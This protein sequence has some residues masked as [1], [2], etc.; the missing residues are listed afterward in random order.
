M[1]LNVEMVGSN[2]FRID[3]NKFKG[4]SGRILRDTSKKPLMVQPN[5]YRTLMAKIRAHGDVS[6]VSI[7]EERGILTF[8]ISIGQLTG[9]RRNAFVEKV[10]RSVLGDCVHKA[11]MP[12]R[13]RDRRNSQQEQHYVNN[14]P[15]LAHR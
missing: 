3:L 2:E 7:D 5:D 14:P 9:S 12:G 6:S 1:I 4:K 13:G 11:E 15:H 8:G 10:V